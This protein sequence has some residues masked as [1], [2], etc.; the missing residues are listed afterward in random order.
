MRIGRNIIISTILALS[1]GGSIVASVAVP[2]AAAQA[3]G[4]HVHV[5]AAAPKTFY[6]G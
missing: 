2:A 4:A 6:R 3:S 1:A 5:T